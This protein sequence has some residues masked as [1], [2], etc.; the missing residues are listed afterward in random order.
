MSGGGVDRGDDEDDDDGG[1]GEP[2]A[3]CLTLG[4]TTG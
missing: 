1:V 3:P 4:C 2:A